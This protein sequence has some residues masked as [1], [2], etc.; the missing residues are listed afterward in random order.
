M[1]KKTLVIIILVVLVLGVGVYYNLEKRDYE[2]AEQ[3]GVINLQTGEFTSFV[4]I[5]S[6]EG[7]AM[8]KEV[9]EQWKEVDD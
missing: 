4:P 6:P 9:Q 1:F 5:D 7:R 3:F 8:E 2:Y